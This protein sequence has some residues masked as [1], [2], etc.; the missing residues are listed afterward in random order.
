MTQILRTTLFISLLFN[1]LATVA[2][3]T[4]SGSVRTID[5]K[6][7]PYVSLAL[8]NARDSTLVKGAI[9]RETGGY[10]FD[11]I[12]PGQYRL[13]ASAV[14]YAPGRTPVVQ[15]GQNPITLP[16]LTLHETQKT[17]SEV[18]VSAQKPMYEQQA[19]RLVVNVQN[20]ITAAGGSAL[21]VLERS[22]GITVNRQS[23][24]L[25][26]SGKGGVL[27]MLNGKLTRLPIAA[28]VQMLEG[29]TANDI[30]K[31]ELITTPPAQYDAE[32]DAGIINIITKKNTSFGTNGNL[33]ASLGYG[34]YERPS[35]SLNLNHR[36]QKLNLYGSYSFSRMHRW[37]QMAYYRLVEQPG[38]LLTTDVV[39]DRNTIYTSQNAKLG[40][41]YTLSPQTTLNG[42]LSGFDTRFTMDATNISNSFTNGVL[43]KQQNLPNSEVNHWQ[44][45]LLNL[46]LRHVFK[47]KQEWSIDLDRL[48]Y[49]NTNP[50][51]YVNDI[52]D[53]IA[54]TKTQQQFRVSKETPIQ[55]W[56]LKTDFLKPLASKGRLEMGL[57]ATI[58]RLNNA[59][60]L[61][62]L[63]AESWTIDS[64]Y[65]QQYHLAENI[66]AG[67]VS[68]NQPLGSQT[69]LQAGL[70]Y[71]HTQTDIYIPGG[72]SLVNW[73]YGNLF[74]S[75]F[76]SHKLAKNH[77]VNFSY[78]RRITR[79]SYDDIAPFVSFVDPNT[80]L[81][82]NPALRPTISDAV[83]GSYT[84]KDAYVFSLKYSVDQNVIAGFQP[85]LDAATN[86]LY[87][88]AENIA[89][90][91][92]L[93]LVG[94]VPWQ[95]S[96]WWKSQHNLTG[97]WQTLNT[98]YLDSPITRTTWNAQINSVHTFTL[99]HKFT[100]EVSGFYVSPSLFGVY[101]FQSYG[102]VT[103]GLQK[104]LPTDKGTL[105]LNVYDVFW[106]GVSRFSSNVPALNI[107]TGGTFRF[108]PRVVRLTYTRN[109]GSK[110]VKAAKNRA[111][112]SEEE[113]TRL[114]N[115]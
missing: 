16:E 106:T 93:S 6:P 49:H 112:G 92:T 99:P 33:S 23:N 32:G 85:H 102:V 50:T 35:V 37:Q 71:E 20:S 44:H 79:P 74:P 88:Y 115:N 42:L 53:F 110:T 89:H 25:A 61:N 21:D 108:E 68:L 80:Y 36:R 113:R 114:Q 91:Q 54:D 81:S 84:F 100:A 8:L 47:N 10:T 83:Q 70:R 15:V 57:K 55:M 82:G 65:S 11:N 60:E 52:Q 4:L 13:A 19:D 40:F 95:I 48:Y 97:L 64:L 17:L 7:L 67:Y 43:S 109:F 86:R 56:V 9:S 87:Y 30:E 63:T 75:V 45:L 12:R 66:L 58:T 31:I 96:P 14:G 39:T 38:Q 62:R 46:N 103:V 69:T 28:V 5:N 104:T 29:M 18:T 27:V 76:V 72:K 2:Q 98:V 34:W 3:T 77:T 111:T 73:R 51:Q 78:S 107:N 24:S 26:M 101:R 94:S 1:G 105:R 90:Q 59:V 41:D 22:P